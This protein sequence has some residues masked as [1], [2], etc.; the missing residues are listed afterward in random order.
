MKGKAVDK[1]STAQELADAHGV[2]E[3]TIRR[4]GKRAEAL[5]KLA[6]DNPED[7]QARRPARQS[8]LN[9]QGGMRTPSRATRRLNGQE[10][11]PPAVARQLQLKP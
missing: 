3:R 11:T 7:A 8:R 1:M 10:T 6:L 4:D 2:D 5:D 9:G